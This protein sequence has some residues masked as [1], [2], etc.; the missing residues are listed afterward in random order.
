M[1]A[2]PKWLLLMHQLPARPTNVRVKT[3]RR[4]QDVGAVAV[5]NSVYALPNSRQSREDFE[6]IKGEIEAMKG[7]ASVFVADA[8]D[9]RSS[10]ELVAT[11]RRN[12]GKEYEALAEDAEKL[13]R[14]VSAK[15]RRPSRARIVRDLKAFRERAAEIAR[16]DFFAVGSGDLPSTLDEVEKL[17]E[18][19][20]RAKSEPAAPPLKRRDFRRRLWV[21]RPRPGIDRMG[22]AW[23]IRRFID[24]EAR[25]AFADRAGSSPDSVPFDMYGVPFGHQGRLCTMEVLMERFAVDDPAVEAIA[26]IV[27]QVDLKDQRHVTAEAPAL[28]RLV[29]GLLVVCPRDPELLEHGMLLFEALYRS[30]GNER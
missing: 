5:K 3:W 6:W 20:P 8:V 11:F 4:L 29:N 18:G 30:F 7:Q 16:R 1:A 22:S 23:L 28:E 17:L 15:T 12:T 2:R 25:F 21:T 13:R 10:E 14:S 24:P 9:G 27:H 19:G 26:R